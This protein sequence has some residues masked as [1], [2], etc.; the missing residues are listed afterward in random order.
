MTINYDWEPSIGRNKAINE[1]SMH[2]S[3]DGIKNANTFYS[4]NKA[5]TA[6]R[7]RFNTIDMR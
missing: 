5:L 6:T 3:I 7:D 2:N 1:K 4:L